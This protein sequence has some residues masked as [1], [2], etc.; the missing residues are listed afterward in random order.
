MVHCSPCP[1]NTTFD[2]IFTFRRMSTGTFTPAKASVRGVLTWRGQADVLEK[3][4]LKGAI[5]V[6]ELKALAAGA[7]PPPAAARTAV[8]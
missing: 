5:A 6:L 3:T 4:P 2:L 1:P 7:T 8:T